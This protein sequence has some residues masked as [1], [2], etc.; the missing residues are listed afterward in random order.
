MFY[1]KYCENPDEY[2]AYSTSFQIEFEHMNRLRILMEQNGNGG[3]YSRL[4]PRYYSTG[5]TSTG[6]PYIEMEYLTGSTLENILSSR[7]QTNTPQRLLSH[8]QIL[9]IYEQLHDA[10]DCLYQVGI[11]QLDLSPQNI[12]VLN[13]NFDIKLI[14][15]TNCYYTCYPNRAYKALDNRINPNTPVGIQ[16]R[17]AGALLFTRLFFSG[18][19][20][21]HV[22]FSRENSGFF[23]RGYYQLLNCL[24]C[25]DALTYANADINDLFY[26]KDWYNEL[27]R[28]LQK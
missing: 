17:D 8:Q 22:H 25:P 18:K 13:E 3:L 1:Y 11:I 20:L 14:D 9:H 28:I 7:P 16:L 21:Y 10:I 15:F 19:E 4:F 27:T 23:N 12:F 2:I 24:F 5:I 26:W 6:Q